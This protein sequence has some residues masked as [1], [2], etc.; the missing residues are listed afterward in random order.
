[1]AGEPEYEP[2]VRRPQSGAVTAIAIVNFVLG[3]LYALCGVIMMAAMGFIANLLGGAVQEAAAKSGDPQVAKAAEGGGLVAMIAGFGIVAGLCVM[4][5][6]ALPLIL[7]GVGVV[8]RRQW[9]RILTL[10]MGAILGLLG[11]INLFAGLR[12]G[13][14]FGS[15]I[16]S[17]ILVGYA[18]LAYVVL[19][20]SQNAAE[21]S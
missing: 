16:G 2:R 4:V 17:L 7:A 20:N 13:V 14:N 18:V 19:L 15:L 6:L 5:I 12:A 1:M 9:G 21:F 11:L 3:G 10:V 8:K